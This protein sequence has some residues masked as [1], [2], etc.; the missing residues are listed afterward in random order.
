MAL[1]AVS[2]LSAA[3]GRACLCFDL[4]SEAPGWGRREGGYRASGGPGRPAQDAGHRGLSWPVTR[5]DALARGTGLRLG[6]VG[7]CTASAQSDLTGRSFSPGGA[8]QPAVLQDRREALGILQEVTAPVLQD[9]SRVT[10]RILQEVRTG[11][12]CKPWS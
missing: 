6:G 7:F 4:S 10:L 2:P 11:G 12:G 3:R 8:G 9:N 5:Q 1:P